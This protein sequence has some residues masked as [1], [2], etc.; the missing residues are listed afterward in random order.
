MMNHMNMNTQRTPFWGTYILN[1]TG[2]LSER[3]VLKEKEEKES[4]IYLARLYEMVDDYV[5]QA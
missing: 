2:N 3:C 4:Q 5:E 1:T